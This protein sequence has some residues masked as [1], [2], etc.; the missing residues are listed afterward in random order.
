MFFEVEPQVVPLITYE[1]G[2]YKACSETLEWLETL[3]EFGV[4]SCAG[5]YR[6]GKSFM[7]NRLAQADSNEGFGVGDSV[8]A[9]TKGLW[10]FKKVFVH[11]DKKILFVD[12][13]GIDALDADD[14]HDVRIFTLALLL[15]STFLYNSMGPIDETAL[16]TLSLM[17]RVTE[18]VK[19]DSEETVQDLSPHMPKFFWILRDFNL[20]LTNRK[21]ES[22]T[23]NEYLDEALSPTNDANKN[24]VREAIRSSFS[25]RRLIT[26]PRPSDK[27][28]PSQRMEDRLINLSK[29]F[30]TRLDQ[31]RKEIFDETGCLVA[32]DTQINGKMYSTLCRHYVEVIQSNAVPVIKDSWTLLA[33]VKARDLKDELLNEYKQTL[34]SI[35]PKTKNEL[36]QT[37]DLLKK[38]TVDSFVKKCMKPV[39]EEVKHI[40]MNELDTLNG[41][42][43]HRL[44]I[45]ITEKVEQ[46]LSKLEEKINDNPEEICAIMNKELTDF[47]EEHND[48]E[49]IK[50]W[51]VSA[52][53]R[54]LCRWIPRSLH[55]LSSQRDDK[56]S[57]LETSTTNY[58]N[59]LLQLEEKHSEALRQER[60]QRSELEQINDSL[61]RQIK[62]ENDENT[63]LQSELMLLSIDMRQ[64]E[65][66]RQIMIDMEPNE[67][68]DSKEVDQASHDELEQCRIENAELR[69]K[70]SNENN[71]SEKNKRLYSDANERLERAMHMHAQLE[72]NWKEGI[73][74]L[75]KEQQEGFMKQKKDFDEKADLMKLDMKKMKEES[76][77]IKN[78]LQ[79][80]MD[81][82]RRLEERFAQETQNYERNSEHLK[83][84][85]QKYR[86]Q[87][88]SAQARVL[89]IHK[90]MLEDLRTRDEKNRIQQAKVIK[91]T[92]EYQQQISGMNRENERQKY[93]IQQMKKRISTLE[94]NEVECKRMKISEK[95]KDILVTQLRTE[96]S[97][98]RSSNAEMISEREMLRRENMQMEGTISL[99]RAEKE[100][101][102]ARRKMNGD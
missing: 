30:K 35:Q 36:D 11:D 91:E 41:E 72:Q 28:D 46:S 15:S 31:L 95:E 85:S 76:N 92:T 49:F 84:S 71:V 55:Y 5:K 90:G 54:A 61:S 99:L 77:S 89:E 1:N 2:E 50:A 102:E 56:I 97:E 21:N 38:K 58:E 74:K 75:R 18:N 88:E 26:L 33:S 63:R 27:M 6:T 100:L 59:L 9:C 13:E 79:N 64:V 101:L 39:D 80:T 32:Q 51:M 44:E 62:D 48:G 25:N 3:G 69:A 12:T 65:E 8:Q 4:V 60:I 83:D 29:T 94:T 70:L 10:L 78:D 96:G 19:F 16:Q 57:E 7:L 93:E 37:L 43:R 42:A 67:E 22:I 73:E 20:K 40:L 45:N 17:T 14:T 53:E 98:L 81:D 23:E 68:K 52:S 34:L 87:A 24:S 82:K 86:E 66:M 47:Q